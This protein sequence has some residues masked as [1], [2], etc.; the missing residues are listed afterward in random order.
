[1][2]I[3]RNNLHHT[4]ESTYYS[5]TK[6]SDHTRSIFPYSPM[7]ATTL[8]DNTFSVLSQTFTV[9]ISP[10][11]F[12]SQSSCLCIPKNISLVLGE[13]P[14]NTGFFTLFFL[15]IFSF[16]NFILIR[17]FYYPILQTRLDTKISFC[18]RNSNSISFHSITIFD[19][20]IKTINATK[21]IVI[22]IYRQ[23]NFSSHVTEISEQ[24]LDCN[25][26]LF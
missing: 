14:E 9:Q 6:L 12:T 20:W 1:M 22:L 5:W 3:R 19:E 8:S 17:F 24:S 15:D 2:E 18:R 4:D 11:I 7:T 25:E 23:Y 26:R 10:D 16:S 13:S 21:S